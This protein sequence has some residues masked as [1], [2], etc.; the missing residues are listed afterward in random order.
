MTIVGNGA[1]NGSVVAN[2][3]SLSGNAEF[4]YDESLA[5]FGGGNPFRV[6]RWKELTVASDRNYYSSVMTF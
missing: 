2:N 6:S 3:I 5:N 1:V 4:H